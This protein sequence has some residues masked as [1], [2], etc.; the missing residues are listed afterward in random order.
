MSECF[1]SDK[2]D[3]L[4]R[5]VVLTA[6][7]KQVNGMWKTGVHVIY[8][9]LEVDSAMGLTLRKVAVMRLNKLQRRLSPLNSWDDVL[10]R[11]VHVANGLRMV[12]S[13]K[14]SKCDQC[15]TKRKKM[16]NVDFDK[17]VLC[18]DCRGKTMCNEGRAY[19]AFLLL[20]PLG[21]KDVGGT[22]DLKQNHLMCVTL[23]S[24]R[25]FKPVGMCR[26]RHFVLPPGIAWEDPGAVKAHGRGA[27]LV[28]SRKDFRNKDKKQSLQGN[29][30]LVPVLEQ[31]LNSNPLMSQLGWTCAENPYQN[32]SVVKVTYTK[33]NFLVNVEG[34]GSTYCNNKNGFHNSSKVYFDVRTRHLVQRCFCSKT[35]SSDA[36]A[37]PCKEYK[38]RAVKLPEDLRRLLFPA[39]STPALNATIEEI[40][41]NVSHNMEGCAVVHKFPNKQQGKQIILQRSWQQYM[42][43][44]DFLKHF[45][46]TT[47]LEPV[48]W[49]KE[50]NYPST[51][52]SQLSRFKTVDVDQFTAAELCAMSE[53]VVEDLSVKNKEKPKPRK[54][55]R[56]DND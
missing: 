10:D 12:G 27:T 18:D 35:S 8:P 11:C 41:Q 30:Q 7:P 21:N 4:F 3:T 39:A 9:D 42:K 37:V 32:V 44:L 46:I 54:R 47:P 1:P 53:K 40:R 23:S 29:S 52:S 28:V 20:D 24:I 25:F 22:E 13:V 33:I 6:P 38:S 50:V 56:D 45:A 17:F 55:K 31:F 19:T 2:A 48:P 26:N 34:P 43:R 14:M 49:S 51:V 36:E 16:K 5:T 15:A